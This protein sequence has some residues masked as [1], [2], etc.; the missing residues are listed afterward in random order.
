MKQ[1]KYNISISGTC[2]S[3]NCETTAEI[4]YFDDTFKPEA[5]NIYKNGIFKQKIKL[6]LKSL[7]NN[8]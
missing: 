5:I 2:R 3:G 4:E 7:I 8:K 6:Q 1:N